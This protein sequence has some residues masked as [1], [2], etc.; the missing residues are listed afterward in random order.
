M[1]LEIERKF[2]V[3]KNLWIP[4]NE[5]VLY[6]QGYIYTYNGNTVRVRV[7]ENQGYLT[8]KGRTKGSARS[9]FEYVIPLEEAR[10]MLDLLCDRPLIEKIRYKEK[11]GELTW[12]IDEFLGEN[13]GLILA[14]VELE[15]EDQKVTL[16]RWIGQ[17]V[18]QHA[19]YY[20][21]NLAKNPY[22][23]W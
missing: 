18:T 20:N 3:N 23:Q 4:L 19:R 8:L 9:E 2:L 13:K 6:R 1:G 7:A 10:E 17:E 5:G 14:E 11:I 15:S 22:S 16:P 21:S 12:E